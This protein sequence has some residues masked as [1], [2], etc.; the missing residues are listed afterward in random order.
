MDSI[1]RAVTTVSQAIVIAC[2]LVI[3]LLVSAETIARYVFFSSFYVTN[4][5][6]VI[7]LVWIGYV[8]CSLAIKEGGHAAFEVLQRHLSRWIGIRRHSI[9]IVCNVLIAVFALFLFVTGIPISLDAIGEHA[10]ASGISQFWM[11]IAAPI[12]AL[13][14]LFQ[15]AMLIRANLAGRAPADGT[16]EVADARAKELRDIY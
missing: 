7:L 1:A 10:P 5:V 8:G 9:L 13:L 14:M 16:G 11:F 2:M 6:A 4:E 15:L 3:T 12:G